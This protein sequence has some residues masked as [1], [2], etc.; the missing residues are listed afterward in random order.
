MFKENFCIFAK[1]YN[2]MNPLKEKIFTEEEIEKFKRSLPGHE[3]DNFGN[4]F[5]IPNSLK[6]NILMEGY[7]MTYPPE[8][9][10][11]YLKNRYGEYAIIE[12]YERDNGIIVFRIG[13]YN[14]EDSKRIVD[15]DMSLCGYYPSFVEI[16]GNTTQYI[17]YEPRNQKSVNE[18]VKTKKYVYHFT[19]ESLYEKIKNVGLC[20][21]TNNKRFNYPE[22]VYLMLE[23]PTPKNASKFITQLMASDKNKRDDDVYVLLKIA[24]KDLDMDFFFDPNAENCVYIKE[25]ILPKFISIEERYIR[26]NR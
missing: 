1:K 10:K 14:D 11:K 20:P 3:M 16:I 8:K 23:K 15:K 26:N 19:K 5:A 7:Y 22:R 2:P 13:V 25:N 21:R 6:E 12:T 4:I 9:V 17:I 24:T 18:I